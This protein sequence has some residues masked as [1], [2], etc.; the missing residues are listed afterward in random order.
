MVAVS[1]KFMKRAY[2]IHITDHTVNPIT[3]TE[4]PHAWTLLHTPPKVL[5]NN[6][7]Y[8]QNHQSLLYHPPTHQLCHS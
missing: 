2:L 5:L 3:A 4:Y 7:T 1:T 6:N 8:S